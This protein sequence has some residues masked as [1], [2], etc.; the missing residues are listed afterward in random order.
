M[1][2]IVL[3]IILFSA[4]DIE[5]GTSIV[6]DC[7]LTYKGETTRLIV[8]HALYYMKYMDYIYIMDKGL[9]IEEGSYESI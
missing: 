6:K 8:T 7:L 4:V 2:I 5:V 3:F 9:I 1:I